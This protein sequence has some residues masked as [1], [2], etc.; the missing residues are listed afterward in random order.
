MEIVA[1]AGDYN[2]FLA[3][4]KAGADA[5]Y[6]GIK[7]FGARRRAKN[8]TF[9]ELRTALDYAHL[10]GVKIYLTLN[11]VIK[12][13][14][15]ESLYE[16]IKK[17][18]EYGVD[19]IIVQDFGLLRFIRK[20]FSDIEIH[21]STQMTISNADEINF[22]KKFGITRVVPARELDYNSIKKIREK[23]DVEL[24][25]FVSGALC[26]SYSGN[27][28]M[29]SF[30]GGRSGNRGM[31]AQ[32]CRKEYILD[33]N[34]EYILS[35]KDQLFRIDEIKKLKEIGINSI[36][37]EG[38]MKSEEYV[39]EVVNY[40]RN[41][42]DDLDRES[43]IE[44]IFNRGYSKG[45]FYNDKNLMNKKYA[46]HFGYKIGEK[47]S[48]NKF[49]LLDS[50]VLGDGIT[51]V[52]K[53]LNIL[54]GY[55]INKIDIKS[56]KNRKEAKKDDIIIF[57]KN[58]F[59]NLNKTEYIYKNYNKS[60]LDNINQKIKNSEKKIGINIEV[61]ATLNNKL[62]IKI[63]YE[64]INIEKEYFVIKEAKKRATTKEKIIEKFSE[65][66]DTSFFIK[67]IK[68]EN[69]ENIF[70]P[71]SELKN[72][73]RE[74]IKE[75]ENEI[76]K[77]KKRVVNIKKIEKFREKEHKKL[78]ISVL[79]SNEKQY[80]IA[81]KYL[82][83]KKIDE[84]YF[85]QV[86]VANEK[87]L[88][89]IDLESKLCTNFYQVINNKNNKITLDKNFN[90]TNSYAIKELEKIDK[91]ETVY[92][93]QELDKETIKN[94]K[95]EKINKALVVYGYLKGMYIE[96]SIFDNNKIEFKNKNGDE[97]IGIKNKIG[98]VE[99]YLKEPLNLIPKLN[100]IKVL[101][102]DEIRLDFIFETEDEMIKILE[103]L[104]RMNGEYRGYNFDTGV[105]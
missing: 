21:A 62:K 60:I 98:N 54:Y 13:I 55:N 35:P 71:L 42:I 40:Y 100:E 69:D 56:S 25:M 27:C 20:N 45:Y 31:C 46:S 44:K 1:P 16:N 99:I 17:V 79:V 11:T 14:E 105:L 59:E 97:F 19:A 7:G 77:S 70:L 73:R 81:K 86:E 92:L 104:E 90:I 6:L 89:K 10:R 28:Y 32:P 26:I 61:I 33:T 41:L 96:Y 82:E 37:I 39:Y 36:K 8:F 63:Y 22:F 2:K 23:T 76:L 29:S 48:D 3:A 87:N 64:N 65:L 95:S 103:S 80:N 43:N 52:D 94:I 5:V 68:I 72:I 88:D 91:V 83:N 93:S 15:L 84:I 30:I 78:R 67:N 38:R 4:V 75:L 9:E 51:F 101:N 34:K 53:N 50:V 66:G 12:D 18:Y 47:I 85:K 58:L 49:K 74:I 102:L 24:E 57:R